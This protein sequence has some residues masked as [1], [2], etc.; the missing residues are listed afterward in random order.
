M[1]RTRS[2]LVV[3]L[4]AF[5]VMVRAFVVLAPDSPTTTRPQHRGG[6]L[7]PKNTAQR[8]S[9]SLRPVYDELLGTVSSR[10]N[11][12]ITDFAQV[13]GGQVWRSPT[14]EGTAEWLAEASPQYL[15]GVNACTRLNH[16]ST[17]KH[18]ELTLNVW[19][20]PSYD[21]PHLLL[22]FGENSAGSGS[23]HITA[24]YVP[25]GATVMGGD[26]QYLDQYYGDDVRAAW[27]AVHQTSVPLPPEL[28]FESRLLDSPARLSASGLRADQASNV[29]RTHVDRF[30]TWI[31]VAQ[32]IPARLR[33]SF[34]MRDDK[35]RQFYYRGQVQK[36]VRLL[37]N[38]NGLG[39]L[40]AA[41]N[42]GPTAEAYVGG[43]S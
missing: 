10:L 32:P 12:K 7:L 29:A 39:Q 36:Q 21:V 35:L 26:P 19:M 3:V 23:Y 4:L 2:W 34:N 41:V 22:S 33:G 17:S 25:R 40:V 13:Y 27:T 14:A 11:L 6:F 15:T 38:D 5:P 30:L 37:G 9:M 18:E 1:I 20:G 8:L 43:G 24:D 42:T 16:G 31:S 28:E